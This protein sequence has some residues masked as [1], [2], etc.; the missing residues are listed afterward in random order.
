[1]S[2]LCTIPGKH[3]DILWSL[4]TVRAIADTRG[5]PVDLLISDRYASHRELI[6]RQPYIG[7]VHTSSRWRHVDGDSAWAPFDGALHYEPLDPPDADHVIH[8]GYR[9]RPDRPLAQFI[10]A[11]AAASVGG[12]LAPLQLD[13]PWLEASSPTPGVTPV[14]ALGWSDDQIEYK[15]VLSRRL[16]QAFPLVTFVPVARNWLRAAE[17]IESAD[18]LVGC[19]SAL[20][21]VACA[22]GTPALIIEPDSRR[23]DPILYPHGTEGWQTQLVRARGVLADDIP[24]IE[25][26]IDERLRRRRDLD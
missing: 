2:A 7:R 17:Q 14:I 1:M 12:I 6:E 26:E 24:Q 18:L 21:V 8:L 22:L 23:W 11:Q 25:R 3:G 16:A 9:R 4:P 15:T 20:H 13:Q 5:T 10:Y 19:C